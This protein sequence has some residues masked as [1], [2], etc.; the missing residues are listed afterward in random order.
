[1]ILVDKYKCEGDD[2]KTTSSSGAKDRKVPGSRSKIL[3]N[4]IS[5]YME[6]RMDGLWKKRVSLQL[7]DFQ[8]Y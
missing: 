1:M 5:D 6:V 8:F 4:L 2:G 7:F 3:K